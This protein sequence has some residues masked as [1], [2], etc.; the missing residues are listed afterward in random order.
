MLTI[1]SISNRKLIRSSGFSIVEIMVVVAIIGLLIAIAVPSYFMSRSRT[2]ATAIANSFR[3]YASAF[4]VEAS[5][6]I[7]GGWPPDAS[8][9]IVPAGMEGA[10]PKWTEGSILGGKWDW[11]Y[12]SVGVTAGISLVASNADRKI[13]EKVDDILDDGDLSTGRFFLNG[14]RVTYVLEP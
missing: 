2:Q 1:R 11:E 12:K 6:L 3:V 8:R 7:G 13:L 4:E 9:G 14:D 5:D 10:L